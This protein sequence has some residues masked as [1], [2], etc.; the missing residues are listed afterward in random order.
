[1]TKRMRTTKTRNAKKYL[2]ARTHK[3]TVRSQTKKR[4]QRG[5]MIR[6]LKNA[7]SSVFQTPSLVYADNKFVE[8]LK[9]LLRPRNKIDA[10]SKATDIKNLMRDN[11]DQ[12]NNV[13]WTTI[14]GNKYTIHKSNDRVLGGS[15]ILLL[16]ILVNVPEYKL[17]RSIYHAFLDYGG[18]IN[19]KTNPNGLSL[20]EQIVFDTTD[21]RPGKKKKKGKKTKNSASASKEKMQ[22]MSEENV[23]DEGPIESVVEEEPVQAQLEED[24]VKSDVEPIPEQPSALPV[25][26][27]PSYDTT[28]TFWK[29]LF[30]GTELN[31]LKSKMD[32]LIAGDLKIKHTDIC[33]LC[34]FLKTII[35]SFHVSFESVKN[36][37]GLTV[38]KQPRDIQNTN[39]ILC[40]TMLLLG[41]IAKKL[42][43]QDYTFMFKG[44]KGVQLAFAH[45]EKKDEKKYGEYESEDIDLIIIP[46]KKGVSYDPDKAKDLALNISYLIRWFF[47]TNYKDNLDSQIMATNPNVV[48]FAYQALRD[49]KTPLGNKLALMDIDFSKIPDENIPFYKDKIKM[50]HKKTNDDGLSEDMLFYFQSLKQQIDEKLYYYLLYTK[51]KKMLQSRPAIEITDEKY[52]TLTVNECKYF[53]KKFNKSLVALL[54]GYGEGYLSFF[55][56][57]KTDSRFSEPLVAEVQVELVK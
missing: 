53:L 4:R 29:P 46:N 9:P 16:Q 40:A 39:I 15:S 37:N 21:D 30:P 6:A 24:V 51:Y 8:D 56:K 2:V 44:G 23:D 28:L 27:G 49:D 3:R 17:D 31:D 35:P 41:I 1:M 55:D 20:K 22:S 12:L 52:K 38:F 36:I 7:V 43:K 14:S 25:A 48:K 45:A 54:R 47:E 10:A 13:I 42:E 33:N 5:G 19:K 26:T 32:D 57:Y 50:F 18:D 11:Q 34:Q